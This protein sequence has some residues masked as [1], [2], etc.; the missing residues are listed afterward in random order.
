MLKPETTHERKTT[1]RPRR[2]EE[3]TNVTNQGRLH[4]LSEDDALKK[5]I[6]ALLQEV[7]AAE[8]GAA[9]LVGKGERPAGRLGDRSGYDTRSLV[10]RVGKLELRA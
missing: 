2:N 4:A 9:L 6:Q 7:L 8:M 3:P 10:T 5:R 1:N